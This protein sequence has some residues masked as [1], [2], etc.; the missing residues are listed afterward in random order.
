MPKEVHRCKLFGCSKAKR[1]KGA[2][3]GQPTCCYYC[4]KKATCPSPCL[5][6]PIEP[7]PGS[8]SKCGQ[9]YLTVIT[10]KGRRY[11]VE[12]AQECDKDR[13]DAENATE[14]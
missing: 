14:I 12:D 2:A 4:K 13:K 6:S 7:N 3:G 10:D 9:H 5:N 1:G 11:K 8:T